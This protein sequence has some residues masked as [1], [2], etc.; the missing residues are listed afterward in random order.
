M[1]KQVDVL[2]F[3]FPQWQGGNNPNYAFGAELLHF[4]ALEGKNSKAIRVSVAENYNEEL[5]V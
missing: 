5:L 4:I 1:T 3:L 2:R